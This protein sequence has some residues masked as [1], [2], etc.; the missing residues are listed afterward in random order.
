ML[1]GLYL[2]EGEL[3]VLLDPAEVDSSLGLVLLGAVYILIT[4]K[5][6]AAG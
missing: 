2:I 3:V 6:D 5:C 4:C 1:I